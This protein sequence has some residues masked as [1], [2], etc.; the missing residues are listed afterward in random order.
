MTL[1]LC[2]Q[3]SSRVSVCISFPMCKSF[4]FLLRRSF[5]T[6]KSLLWSLNALNGGFVTSNL[7]C[8][9]LFL[10]SPWS[11]ANRR[12]EKNMNLMLDSHNLSWL[13]PSF[14]QLL[15]RQIV[16]I[17]GFSPEL[18]SI[19][20]ICFILL[21]C[22]RK[23]KRDLIR[24]CWTTGFKLHSSIFLLSFWSGV[25]VIDHSNKKKQKNNNNNTKRKRF[26][27]F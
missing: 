3:H 16:S 25:F 13:D 22:A 1:S 7:L 18:L 10:L 9:S 11:N 12:W 26:V 15:D 23:R 24:Y 17:I 14:K 2:A 6:A 20:S 19:F 5:E 27:T 21:K 8:I 4:S